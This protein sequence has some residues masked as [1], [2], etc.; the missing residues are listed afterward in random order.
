MT[1]G[2]RNPNNFLKLI[3]VILMAASGSEL[4]EP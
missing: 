2:I 1:A 4:T 3:V